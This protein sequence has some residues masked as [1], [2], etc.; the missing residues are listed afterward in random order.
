MD[1]VVVRRLA[2]EGAGCRTISCV[3]GDR[4]VDDGDGVGSAGGI[5]DRDLEGSQAF[6]LANAFEV[7]GFGF[8]AF[9]DN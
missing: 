5:D 8:L 7:L 6:V 3:Y 4:A 9:A 1:G 2:L